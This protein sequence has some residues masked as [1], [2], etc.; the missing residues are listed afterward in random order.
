MRVAVIVVTMLVA[1]T[2]SEASP[3]CMNQAEARQHFPTLHL[4]WHGPDHCWDA[5]PAQR[6]RIR[7][8]QR[9]INPPSQPKWRNSMSAMLADDSLAPSL[10][11]SR[12]APQDGNDVALGT[13]W[14][15]RWIDIEQSPV[16]ARWVEIPQAA[17]APVVERKAEPPFTLRSAILVLFAFAL[18]LATIEVLFRG[19]IEQR[20]RS[21]RDT[22]IEK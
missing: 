2:P 21:G 17:A 22:D 1:A 15:D 16:A 13:P 9:K 7:Q 14:R 3:S 8:V 6:H 18:T 4:Y 20:P 19:S 5:T 11:A 12:D 10:K